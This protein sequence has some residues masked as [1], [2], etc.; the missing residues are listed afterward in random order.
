MSRLKRCIYIAPAAV[1]V[2]L[3]VA[4]LAD[5]DPS[6]LNTPSIG[7]QTEDKTIE[8][9]SALLPDE[10]NALMEDAVATVT[11]SGDFLLPTYLL[12]GEVAT[13]T[14]IKTVE[15][16][17]EGEKVS[18]KKLETKKNTDDIIFA[19][20][21]KMESYDLDELIK[22]TQ[23]SMSAVSEGRKGVVK[24]RLLIPLAPIAQED[25]RE[26]NIPNKKRALIQS[27]YADQILKSLKSGEKPVF[28]IPHEMRITFYPGAASF[29]GQ[30]LKW[31]KAFA[32]AAL[33]DPR[34]VVEVRASCADAVLQEKRL[35]LLQAALREMG[36]ST[37]QIVV[38]YSN[39]QVDTMLLMA[40]P[41]P[42]RN[43]ILAVPKKEK[44]SKNLRITKW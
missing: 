43:E 31:V 37:H 9:S 11:A 33:E 18:E 35:L 30:T 16:T 3:S 19:D 40:V 42:E 36:L 27:D 6:E 25:E 39:R 21:Q 2:M 32:I 20:T 4:A 26:E 8:N 10:K 15:Q 41:R 28:A 13:V 24:E 34:L 17:Y 22:E 29:S 14:K 1:T 5:G 38:D 44:S 23:P 7:F 12:P